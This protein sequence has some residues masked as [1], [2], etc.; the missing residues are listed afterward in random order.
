MFIK[1]SRAEFSLVSMHFPIQIFHFPAP[2]NILTDEGPYHPI[3]D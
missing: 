2:Y 3:T 1:I